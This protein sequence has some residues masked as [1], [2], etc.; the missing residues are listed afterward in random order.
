MNVGFNAST[1]EQ[2]CLV[3]KLPSILVAYFFI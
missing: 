1:P 2:A 3:R